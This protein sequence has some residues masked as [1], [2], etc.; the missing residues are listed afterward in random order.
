MRRGEELLRD[1][2]EL[3][4]LDLEGEALLQV[5]DGVQVDGACDRI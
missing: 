3:P 5:A 4:D 2:P 1:L